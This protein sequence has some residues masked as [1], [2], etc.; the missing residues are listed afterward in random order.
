[1]EISKFVIMVFRCQY[2]NQRMVPASWSERGV[3]RS[4]RASLPADFQSDGSQT[5]ITNT[6]NI[7]KPRF[8]IKF[9]WKSE[10]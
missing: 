9:R 10:F 4:A 1:M 8:G 2:T 7:R 6:E 5:S 3:R